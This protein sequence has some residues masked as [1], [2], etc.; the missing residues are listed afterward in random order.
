[1]NHFRCFFL[2]KRDF[3]REVFFIFSTKVPNNCNKWTIFCVIGLLQKLLGTLHKTNPQNLVSFFFWE[4][5]IS[6]LETRPPLQCPIVSSSHVKFLSKKFFR[7]KSSLKKT[8]NY[9]S[10]THQLFRSLS[11][12]SGRCQTFF[13]PLSNIDFWCYLYL[14]FKLETFI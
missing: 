4:G 3:S 7:G 6:V 14:S 12:V 8:T 2:A 5:L 10:L 9:C 1:M 13:T 11:F